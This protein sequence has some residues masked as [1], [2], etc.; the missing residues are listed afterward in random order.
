MKKNHKKYFFMLLLIVADETFV[1]WKAWTNNEYSGRRIVMRRINDE[2]Y[3]PK[4]AFV[5]ESVVVV[6]EGQLQVYF[7][8][9]W[10]YKT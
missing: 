4:V 2:K 5:C 9:V 7:V 8:S 10:T 1:T 3:M 6:G